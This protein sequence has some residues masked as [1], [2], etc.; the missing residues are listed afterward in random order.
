MGQVQDA[1]KN[2]KQ[3]NVNIKHPMLLEMMNWT[4]FVHMEDIKHFLL[5]LNQNHNIYSSL[6]MLVYSTPQK[7][8]VSIQNMIYENSFTN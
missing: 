7:T 5:T 4:P 2:H 3:F 8:H 1:S 6:E